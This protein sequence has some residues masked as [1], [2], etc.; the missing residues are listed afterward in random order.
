MTYMFCYVIAKTTDMG[1]VCR[2]T[3]VNPISDKIITITAYNIHHM[4]SNV[5]SVTDR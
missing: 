4:G 2:Y 5:L 1:H 3:E